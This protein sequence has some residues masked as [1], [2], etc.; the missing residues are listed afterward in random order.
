MRI[1]RDDAGISWAAAAALF[2]A[3]GW[4]SRDQEQA[5]LNCP[6]EDE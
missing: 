5:R 4:G 2:A 3:V 1:E 6:K